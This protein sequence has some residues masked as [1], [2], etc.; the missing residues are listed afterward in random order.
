MVGYDATKT[1]LTQS[2][3]AVAGAMG[4]F[5][6]RALTQPFDVVK[7]RFQLQ[8]EPLS[9]KSVDSKYTGVIQAMRTI[10]REEGVI[11]LWKGHNAGQALSIIYGVVQFTVFEALTR[12]ADVHLSF[13]RSIHSHFLF[14]AIAGTAATVTSFPFDVLRT[15]YIA[16]GNN[17]VYR[18]FF[19][20][21]NLLLRN[22]GPTAMFR[23]LSPS[24]IQV[25]PHS[26]AQFAFHNIFSRI[27]KKIS[28]LSSDANT[29]KL[30]GNLIVGSLAGLC[31]KTVV[32]PFDLA[33]KRLQLQGFHNA[34]KGFGKNFTCQGLISCLWL[35]T[36]NE[37]FL[38]LFKGLFPSMLK[39]S[40]TTGL[41]F[42][43]YEETCKMIALVR[44]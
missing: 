16:Q 8:V 15:R 27:V 24:L 40:V 6:T 11:G 2:E 17:K 20:S 13:G 22:E 28:W 10:L 35:T 36:V 25:A 29:L 44:H 34:R 41:Y 23:G 33:R 43:V 1:Q 37:G 42:T 4:G 18:N 26:G 12:Q 9:R 21:L 19:Q 14:G 7:I 3:H 32:Y 30:S 31:A 5:I 39:A 38:S